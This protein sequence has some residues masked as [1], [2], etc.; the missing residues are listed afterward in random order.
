MDSGRFIVSTTCCFRAR[1]LETRK[2]IQS[3]V[4]IY[5]IISV[6]GFSFVYYVRFF[7]QWVIIHEKSDSRLFWKSNSVHQFSFYQQHIGKFTAFMWLVGIIATIRQFL[8]KLDK[9]PGFLNI[10]CWCRRCNKI[11]DPSTCSIKLFNQKFSKTLETSEK[12]WTL[13]CTV[14]FSSYS[15]DRQ[16]IDKTTFSIIRELIILKS[17]RFECLQWDKKA[18][19]HWSTV[20]AY[21]IDFQRFGKCSSSFITDVTRR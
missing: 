4:G 6:Y 3:V 19:L 20:Y 12:Y 7:I 2:D 21:S 11:S 10:L 18:I 14:E 15:I 13:P 16:S 5:L 17:K 8:K 1:V 9:K